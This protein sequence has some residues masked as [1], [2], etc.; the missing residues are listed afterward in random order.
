MTSMAKQLK[1]EKFK[2]G[3]P[4]WDLELEAFRKEMKLLDK[5]CTVA[6]FWAL[7]QALTEDYSGTRDDFDTLLASFRYMV[8][9]SDWFDMED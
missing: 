1:I 6:K 8:T 9:D 4:E 7:V 3:V 2:T 5:R